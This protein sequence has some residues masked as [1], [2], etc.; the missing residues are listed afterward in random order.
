MSS[1]DEAFLI[2]TIRSDIAS[3]NED[4]GFDWMNS[5]DGIRTA[6]AF[7]RQ[8]LREREARIFTPVALAQLKGYFALGCEV[9]PTRISPELKEVSASTTLSRLFRLASTLWSVPV[10][11]GFGRRM[12]FVVLDR[13]NGK[14]IGLMALTDPVFNL[15]VRD[16]EIGWSA[17]DRRQRLA[18]VM[19]ANVLG[20]VP[21]YSTLLG[22]KLLTSF[23]A[24]HEIASRFH[25]KYAGRV[26]IIS[27]ETKIAE[28][29][30]VTVTSALGRSSIYNR[31]VLPGVVE[32]KRLGMTT[33]WG[34]FHIP[35]ST[36][37]LMRRLLAAQGHP[38]S[39]DYHFGRGPNWRFRVIKEA[40]RVCGLDE[41]F[42]RH[43]VQR[44]V[45]AM[46]L[47]DNYREFLRHETDTLWGRPRPTIDEITAAALVRWVEPRAERRPD[48]R[49][50]ARPDINRLFEDLVS[51]PP[52]TSRAAR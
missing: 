27:G 7:R 22:G 5:K 13:Q 33:G 41:S 30:L 43:G 31:V 17:N 47:A 10:S 23:L 46:P 51:S 25:E 20:A 44:E 9:D 26:G 24:S 45:F 15:R 12:R 37:Q 36:F 48:F 32:L 6:Y 49:D 28:L 2:R 35:E 38:Y 19:D 50:W 29:A 18:N 42:M 16:I 14:L 8:A 11:A 1:R 52:A 21:P 3:V 4:L 39:E 40:L 34:H